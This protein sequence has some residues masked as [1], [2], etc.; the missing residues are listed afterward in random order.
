MQ[1]MQIQERYAKELTEAE[2]AVLTLNDNIKEIVQKKQEEIEEAYEK[3]N[4]VL[5][6]MKEL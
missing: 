3:L 5:K 6:K 2:Q 1:I 4:K